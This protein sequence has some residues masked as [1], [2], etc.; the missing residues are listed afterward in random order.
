M[1]YWII[2][3]FVILFV[4]LM[5]SRIFKKKDENISNIAFFTLGS[6]L[7]LNAGGDKLDWILKW[8]AI[9]NNKGY[10]FEMM[11]DFKWQYF[12]LGII[13]IIISIWLTY[14]KRKNV[15]ILNINGYFKR[16]LDEYIEKNKDLS[17]NIREYEINIIDI[18][19][20]LFKN[21]LDNES[22]QCIIGKIK[23]DIN[24]FKNLSESAKKGYTGIAPIPFI[25]YAGTF[26]GR[27]KFDE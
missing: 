24:A 14:Y 20:R 8:L 19:N 12:V 23:E 1:L 10:A 3:I 22:Y 13:L 17:K 18:Y 16:N 9:T 26:L 5:L 2:G 7:I 27:Q 6:T 15:K 11:Q 4:L 25:M 21:N